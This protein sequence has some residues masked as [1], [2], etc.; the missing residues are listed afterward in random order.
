MDFDVLPDRPIPNTCR[1]GVLA[2]LKTA[3]FATAPGGSVRI[4]LNGR[5]RTSLVPQ[6]SRACRDKGLYFRY[7]TTADGTALIMWAEPREQ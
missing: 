7:R 2:L 5:K 1:R 4:P 6:L 3:L